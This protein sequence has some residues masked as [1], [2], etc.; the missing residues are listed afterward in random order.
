MR[1]ESMRLMNRIGGRLLLPALLIGGLSACQSTPSVPVPAPTPPPI[2]LQNAP[3][4][5]PPTAAEAEEVAYQQLR[6]L[7]RALIHIRKD[8]VDPAKT[9]YPALIQGALQGMLQSLDPHSQFLDAEL[10]ENIKNDTAGEFGGIGIV[11]GFKDGVLSVIAPMEG[12]PAFRAGILAGD[13]IAGINGKSTEA[14]NM[15]DAIRLLR[16][17]ENTPVTL[18]IN[19]ADEK[20]PL[21]FKL[22]REP[23]KV[24]SV[25]GARLLDRGIGYIRITQFTEN[26]GPELREA[27]DQLLKKDLRALVLD[28]R[29]NPGGLLNSAIEVSQIFLKP[30]LPIVATRSRD[31]RNDPPPHASAGPLHLTEFPMAILVNEG[32]AS[33]SEIV[34]GALQDHHRA[35]LIGARTF[36][37]ASVQSIFPL[38]ESNALRLTTAHY[39]TPSDRPIHEKGIP[40]DITVPVTPGEWQK[41]LQKRARIE[42]PELFAKASPPEDLAGI[43]D[44]PLE[45]ALDILQGLMIFHSHDASR[46]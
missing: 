34:A 2:A 35:I 26:T 22:V 4:N 23:I 36:G 25:K 27:L 28:L 31:S 7:A 8:Y 16:G 14:M 37:K 38:D 9:E 32:S 20:E 44:R 12:T 3:T 21:E 41:I 40:P 17:P 45:R 39:H 15:R 19:R 33:A 1:W 13:R 5:P 6:L 18:T 10:Y 24:A 46:Q 30:G 42:N 29:N 43:V 11:L